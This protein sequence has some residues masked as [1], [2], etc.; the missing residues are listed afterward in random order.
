MR[1]CHHFRNALTDELIDRAKLHTYPILWVD[2]DPGTPLHKMA[3]GRNVRHLKLLLERCVAR[4]GPDYLSHSMNC[5]ILPYRPVSQSIWGAIRNWAPAPW[6]KDNYSRRPTVELLRDY[7]AE[8]G[9]LHCRNAGEPYC[10]GCWP[11]VP[12]KNPVGSETRSPACLDSVEVWPAYYKF[13]RAS[14]VKWPRRRRRV[15]R[16]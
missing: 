9:D 15:F 6:A 1:T 2:Y 5:E 4:Y 10:D 8:M 3:V 14:R 13:D 11:Y 16:Y 12:K 7:G